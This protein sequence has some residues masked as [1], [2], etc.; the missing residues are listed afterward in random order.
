MNQFKEKGYNLKPYPYKRPKTLSNT[1]YYIRYTDGNNE[2]V[3]EIDSRYYLENYKKIQEQLEGVII[4]RFEECQ[5]DE[6]FIKRS[7]SRR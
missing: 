1:Y 2:G 3:L 4:I 5:K 6:E 7:D